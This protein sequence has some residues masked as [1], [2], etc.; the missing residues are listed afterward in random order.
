MFFGPEFLWALL[1]SAESDTETKIAPLA[2]L[3]IK[4][5]DSDFVP[6]RTLLSA[7]L[8]LATFLFF[9]FDGRLHSSPILLSISRIDSVL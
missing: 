6:K 9:G 4:G 7:A 8:P 3:N 2:A 5:G 1:H